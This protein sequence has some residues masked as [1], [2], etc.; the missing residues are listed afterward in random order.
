MGVRQRARR[1]TKKGVRA[2]R[3][4]THAENR[5]ALLTVAGGDRPRICSRDSG[6]GE[7]LAL[8]GPRGI[9]DQSLVLS[10]KHHQLDRAA[11][12]NQRFA[13]LAS[14]LDMPEVVDEFTQR[15]LW[16]MN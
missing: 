8:I 11:R 12:Q 16:L 6:A 13:R 5:I 10:Q 14:L 1:D 15:R 3:L 4:E 7:Q 9:M 2:A